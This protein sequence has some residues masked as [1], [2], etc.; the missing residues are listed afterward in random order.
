MIEIKKLTQL[1]QAYQFCHA[2]H[3]HLQTGLSLNK[4]ILLTSH[5]KK[6]NIHNQL[7]M[8]HTLSQAI[9]HYLPYLIASQN[10]EDPKHIPLLHQLSLFYHS[11]IVAINHIITVTLYPLSLCLTLSIA[12]YIMAYVIMPKIEAQHLV[13]L[14][15]TSLQ[16]QYAI[17]LSVISILILTILSLALPQLSQKIIQ[18][19]ELYQTIKS[20]SFLSQL[21]WLLGTFTKSGVPLFKAFQNIHFLKK[22]QQ[23]LCQSIQEKLGQTGSLYDAIQPHCSAPVG[24]QIK[25]AQHSNQLNNCLLQLATQL[26]NEQ[27]E[28]IN[29]VIH[30]LNPLLLIAFGCI[31]LFS[32]FQLVLPLMTFAVGKAP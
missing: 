30:H 20:T 24:E 29:T 22:D 2:A 5:P 25:Q 8:G 7:S 9:A 16:L 4:A 23:T 15:Y 1:K 12:L 27:N 28:K 19:S 17:T 11:K 14:P 13:S 6:Q 31:L 26:S 21:F 3:Q 32:I 18:E 10:S